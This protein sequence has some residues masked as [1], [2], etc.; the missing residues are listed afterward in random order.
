MSRKKQ[1]KRKPTAVQTRFRKNDIVTAYISDIGNDG[2]GIAK[3]TDQA[4]RSVRRD[5]NNLKKPGNVKSDVRTGGSYVLF[6]KDAVIGDTVEAKIV[7]P[8]K[9]YAFAR[10]EKVL[11][12]SP[13]RVEP[14]C[15]IARQCGGCQLQ[16]LRYRRQLSYKQNKVRQDLIRI[17][18]FDEN[19]INRVM[20]PIVGMEDPYRY[21]CKE[22]VPFGTIR[23]ETGGMV[24]VCGFY[25]GRTHDIIPMTDCYIGQPENEK[26]LQAVLDWMKRF[27][28]PVYDETA[29]TGVIRH[30]LIR[31]GWHSGEIMACIVANAEEL[32]H[33]EELVNS[34]REL[35]PLQ[36]RRITSI[37][38][39][40]NR[41]QTN[42]IMG[43]KTRVLWGEGS[44][45]D[46]LDILHVRAGRDEAAGERR[47][48]GRHHDPAVF[49]K[50]GESVTFTIS[51]LS[52]Y[53]VNPQQ[54]EKLYSLALEQAG[55]SGKE[56]V[57]DLYCGVGTISLFM[58]RYAGKVYGVEVIPE[59][60]EDARKNAELNGI[61][62]TEFFVGKVEEVLPDYVRRQKE[63]GNRPDVDVVCLDP[64]RKGCDRKCLETILEVGPQRIVYVSCDPATLARDLRI[65]ADGGYR[66]DYVRPCDMFAQT[67]HVETVVCLGKRKP[68][69][70]ILPGLL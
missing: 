34:L 29:G 6:V 50:S 35:N 12:K 54:T 25:A 55:L 30:V 48:D 13:S 43:E 32:L 37:C 26:I 9:S 57:W 66:L 56:T 20:H 69:R 70:I 10:T 5:G 17:G 8:G 16:A 1:T 27:A 64:P 65:L 38:L 39:N 22:Q 47:K 18:K 31:T 4:M 40:I 52:F 46:S 59:A 19:E 2:A 14:A 67:V 15:P 45:E 28:V 63:A 51:P 41:K 23:T 42:V 58:A 36:D 53:Q 44:I 7:K 21:R 62:N 49:E 33:E 11:K 60:I 61:K 3:I 68:G 24:P